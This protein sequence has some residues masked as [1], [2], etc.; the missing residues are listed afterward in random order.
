MNTTKSINWTVEQK[1]AQDYNVWGK[2]RP[3]ALE[4]KK[5][6]YFKILCEE[7]NNKWYYVI[8]KAIQKKLNRSK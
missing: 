2:P 8:V 3:K 1:Y 7:Q 4:G 6:R 5:Q